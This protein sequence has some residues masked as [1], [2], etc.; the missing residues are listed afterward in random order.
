MQQLKS[1]RT[2]AAATTVLFVAS[3][4]WLMT[5]RHVNSSLEAGLQ[6][7]KLK[8]E[9]LLSEKLLLEK[10]IE[11]MKDQLFALK[12]KN[13]E[14]DNLAQSAAAKLRDQE[15][16]YN[17]MKKQN[18][19]LWQ[20]RKQRAELE[21]LRNALENELLVLKASYADLEA[22]NEELNT[23][24]ATLQGRNQ[25]LSEDLQRTAFAAIDQTQVQAVRGKAEKVTAKGR[26][27]RKLITS[28][29]VS[30]DR[31]DLSFRITDLKGRVLNQNDGAIAFTSL[32]SDKNM[33][34]SSASGVQGSKLQEV[35]M[36][37]TP[38]RKLSAGLYTVEILNEGLYVGSLK[39]KLN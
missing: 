24:V 1:P 34:A 33:T 4:S 31:K 35:K 19:S 32:P 17:R 38:K 10:D 39:V 11:K 23:E 13:L 25:R 5:T 18:A 22:R 8:S 14:L 20:I 21:V 6:E 36:E 15:S 9:T 27:T 29:E 30:A 7:Q 3:A 12:G 26:R 2:I 37:Y 16:E 28:F